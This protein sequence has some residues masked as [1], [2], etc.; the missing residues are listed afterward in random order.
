MNFGSLEALMR[1]LLGNQLSVDDLQNELKGLHPK[2]RLQ[3]FEKLD[4]VQ[5]LRESK[6]ERAC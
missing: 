2:Q 6:T 3:L 5:R 1:A 4:E